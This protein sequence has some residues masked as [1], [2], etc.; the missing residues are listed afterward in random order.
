MFHLE[1]AISAWRRTLETNRAL[2]IEDIDELE[3]HIRDQVEALS[4]RG[5]AEEEAFRRAL[6]EIG[7]YDAVEDEYRKVYWSKLRRLDRLSGEL[8]NRSALLKS[9]VKVAWRNALRHRGYAALNIFGLAL[10]MACS[11]LILL[12]VQDELSFDRFHRDAENIYRVNWDFNWNNAEGTGPGTPPPLARTLAEELPDVRLAT[13]LFSVSRMI[14]RPQPATRNAQR[15]DT[16]RPKAGNQTG[17][18]ERRIV[19]ADSNFFDLFDFPLLEGDPHTALAAPNSVVLTESTARKYFGDEPALGRRLTIGESRPI[20]RRFYDSAFTVTGVVADVPHNS[21]IQFDL[22]TSMPSHPEVAQFDWSW[23][24]ML[25]TTYVKLEPGTDVAALDASIPDLVMRRGADAL[26]RIGTDYSDLLEAGGRFTFVFQPMT[27]VYLRAP[28]IGN[29]LGP[30][31]NGSY[32]TIAATIAIFVLLIACI[33]FM[34]LA[35]ARSAT[36]SREVGVRKVLGSPRR[37]LVG[38]FLAESMVFSLLAVP[39]ALVMVLAAFGPFNQLTGK[40]LELNL[41]SPAWLPPV[42]VLLPVLV[43]LI[44]GSYPGIY[45]SSF[46]PIQVLKGTFRPGGGTKRLRHALVVFQFAM[47]I[48]LI[49]FTLLVR[50]QL[51]YMRSVDVGF[52]R[53]GIVL[54]D[55]ESDRLRSQAEVFKE[56]LKRRPEFLSA[57]ITSGI[58]PFDS[59]TDGYQVEGGEVVSITSYLTDEDLIPTLG[60]EI[61][62]GRAF[63]RDRTAEAGSVILNE[64]AVRALGLADPVGKRL[65]YPGGPGEFEI[66]GVMRDFNFLTLRSPVTP[67]ALFHRS[68][69]TY[70]VA[71]SYVAVRLA[72]GDLPSALS[73]LESDWKSVAPDMPFEYS[74]LDETYAEQYQNDRRLGRLFGVFSALAIIIACLGLLGLAAFAAEQRTKEIGIR[75]VLGADVPGLAA[76]LSKDFLKLIAVAFVVAALPAYLAMRGWLEGFVYRVEVGPGLFVATGALVLAVAI[77]TVSYQSVRTALSDPVKSL[78]YE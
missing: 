26:R 14:V 65:L 19:A 63:S 20:F 67:F 17:F 62:E 18:S 5:I 56:R 61:V 64:A 32:V 15:G 40:S 58:P 54:I 30:V 11:L 31:G 21:H 2:L 41:L 34:N 43:G 13:R 38:Q 6:A 37:M 68:S 49:V 27:E 77:L 8:R 42:I 36:R 70:G 22:L 74:F 69:G 16:L 55:N 52:D 10:G 1:K 23:V 4:T 66:I 71:S 59:F 73:L 39:L 76:L 72:G 7:H 48:A 75:K 60:I 57:S 3:R 25:M 9:Y 44:A 46:R 29:R 28:E 24:W 50:Q 12:Y 47:T 35:T 33:N 51:D 53:E 78:R 45:L